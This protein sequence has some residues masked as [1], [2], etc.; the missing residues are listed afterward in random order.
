MFYFYFTES[1]YSVCPEVLSE[2]I[3]NRCA[4][5]VVL[6]PFCGAGG[7]IIQLAMACEKGIEYC[8]LFAYSK[9]LLVN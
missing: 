2:H 6:D 8:Y 4:D 3:A 5:Y 1:F 9:I 7:N